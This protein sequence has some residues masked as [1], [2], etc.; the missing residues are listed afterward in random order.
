MT[1][2]YNFI[3]YFFYLSTNLC[4]NQIYFTVL[5]SWV[6]NVREGRDIGLFITLVP[7][8]LILTLPYSLCLTTLGKILIGWFIKLRVQTFQLLIVIYRKGNF[9]YHHWRCTSIYRPVSYTFRSLIFS[10]WILTYV[11]LKLFFWNVSGCLTNIPI[12]LLK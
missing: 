3:K 11:K 12:K 9:V 7:K 10:K 5:I 4:Q 6:L 8:S 1:F 2:D